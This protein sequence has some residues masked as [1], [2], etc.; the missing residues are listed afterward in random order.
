M[1]KNEFFFETYTW[2]RDLTREKPWSF[3][4]EVNSYAMNTKNDIFS[5]GVSR[6]LSIVPVPNTVT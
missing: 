5:H 1:Y 2:E 4:P 6:V 3:K